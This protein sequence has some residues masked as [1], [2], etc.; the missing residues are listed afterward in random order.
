MRSPRTPSGGPTRHWLE[1]IAAYGR[2]CTDHPVR[3][4]VLQ[5]VIDG[6]LLQGLAT[7]TPPTAAEFGTVLRHVLL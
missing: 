1:V 7:D 3:V 2:R 4:Q 5:G 6:L